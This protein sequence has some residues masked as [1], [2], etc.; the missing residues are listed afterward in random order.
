MQCLTFRLSIFTVAH[1]F[2]RLS[3][4]FQEAFR[5][6]FYPCIYSSLNQWIIV[7]TVSLLVF[8]PFLKSNRLVSM[9][10]SISKFSIFHSP[11]YSS[12]D[13][14]RA[15]PLMW[16][17]FTQS[18]FPHVNVTLVNNPREC[19]MLTFHWLFEIFSYSLG[20]R[21]SSEY[22]LVIAGL[23]MNNLDW[24]E[25]NHKKKAMFNFWF[26]ISQPRLA[27][28]TC[29]GMSNGYLLLDLTF[30]LVKPM[31]KTERNVWLELVCF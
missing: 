9:I 30:Y 22:S 18:T 4:L 27:Y 6:H 29:A 10:S 13:F 17:S 8:I 23:S 12:C 14:I 24:M 3:L 28:E 11:F 16:P 19:W 26:V 7:S 1:A 2:V 25:T 5:R 31:F 15:G 21:S 20:L